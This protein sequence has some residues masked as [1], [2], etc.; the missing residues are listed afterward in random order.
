[1]DAVCASVF[2]L[3]AL[4]LPSRTHQNAIAGAAA[5]AATAFLTCPLDVARTRAQVQHIF[6]GTTPKYN[7]LMR[8]CNHVQEHDG[9]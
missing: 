5:G 6:K 4:T 2:G 1:M 7:G 9:V 3:I 8:K